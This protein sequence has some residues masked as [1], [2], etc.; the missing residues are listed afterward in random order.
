[1]WGW[2]Q[3]N[4]TFYEVVAVKPKSLVIREIRS[5]ETV[6]PPREPNGPPT[7]TGTVVPVPGAYEGGPKTVRVAADGYIKV[8]H[9]HAK[10]WDGEPEHCTHYC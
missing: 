7:M 8:E 4:I 3:T 9:G 1:M 2:E 10:P 5:N 6:T